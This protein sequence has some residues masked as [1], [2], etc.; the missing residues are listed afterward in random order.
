VRIVAVIQARMG[1][2]RLPGKVLLPLRGRPLLER[3]L[4]RVAHAGE[5]DE[6][7]VA[8]TR[9]A[10]D[11]S[12][13]ALAAALGV[14]CVSGDPT[15][16]VSRH[17]L[18]ARA[19]AADAVVKIPS[20]CPLIDPT[21]IDQTVGYFR[22]EFPRYAFVSNLHP[23]T[24]PDG[25]DVEVIARD[26]LEVTGREATRP[27]ERE[28]TTPFIWDQPERFAQGNV[29]W[30]TGLNLSVS[31][32]L[33]LDY[34]ADYALI[35]AVFEALY[36]SDAAPFSVGAIVDYLNAHPEV[37]AINAAH[38]GHSWIAD[39]AHELRTLAPGSA[40]PRDGATRAHP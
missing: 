31:H 5:I 35:A 28:H 8:T 32:R 15:D 36:R 16:L 1:S 19:S 7:V 3:M 27:F 39:H 20:D 25:N 12:I 22:S 4:V 9:L 21:V 2:T 24:W 34:P 38:V 30:S 17:L 13:R 14:R 10:A 29:T 40:A 18:A 37:K 26:V 23:A 11:D 33:T 6:V